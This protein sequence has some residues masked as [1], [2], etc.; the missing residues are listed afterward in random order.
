MKPP[1]REIMWFISNKFS[2]HATTTKSAFLLPVKT[3]IT[4]V[5]GYG[6]VAAPV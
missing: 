4:S 6:T 3:E 1:A 5:T 2:V